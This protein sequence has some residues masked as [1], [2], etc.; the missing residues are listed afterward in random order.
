[1]PDGRGRDAGPSI[2]MRTALTGIRYE[3]RDARISAKLDT[4]VVACSSHPH[5]STV[6]RSRGGFSPPRPQDAGAERHRRASL[7][8]PDQRT[9]TTW[10][11]IVLP[12]DQKADAVRCPAPAGV[13]AVPGD[14][15]HRTPRELAEQGYVEARCTHPDEDDFLVVSLGTGELT[16]SLPYQEVKGWGVVRWA[17]PVLSVVFDGINNTVDYQLRQLLRAGPDGRRRYYRLQPRLEPGIDDMDRTDR[18]HLRALRLL[19]EDL[20]RERTDELDLL[21]QQLVAAAPQ[22]KPEPQAPAVPPSVVIA[23]SSR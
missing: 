5:P 20:I 11:R 14:V 9:R 22:P 15:A 1:M 21:C 4:D 13:E 18:A 16:R 19:G 10:P 3:P 17:H 2:A 12:V 6:R 8:P 7:L 23:T